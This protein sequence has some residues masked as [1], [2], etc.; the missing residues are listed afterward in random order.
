MNTK[1]FYFTGTG[2]SFI[3]AKQ[4]AERLQNCKLIPI[5]QMMKKEK[6][7]SIPEKVGFVFPLYYYGLPKIVNDFI[8]KIDLSNS[9]Y[10]FAIITRAGEEDGASFYQLKELFNTKS[11]TLDAEF[12]VEMPNNFIIEYPA[13][14]KEQQED[15]FIKAIEEIEQ[16]SN[17]INNNE[18]RLREQQK[19]R[20]YT[21]FKRINEEFQLKV[22]FSDDKFYFDEN[23]TSC[24]ICQKICPVDNILLIDGKPHWQHQCQQ[25]LACI[26]YCP[27]KSI[28]YDG[29][30][31]SNDRY[32]HP[33]V[34]IK[35]LVAQK[36]PH[37]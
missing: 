12:A 30:R 34:R 24:G 10:H 19:T 37:S 7:S 28:K 11:K 21:R 17:F 26:N 5:V 1:L 13:E 22:N 14:T 31:S 4:L 8:Q 6:V 35:D 29:Q 2:N 20:Y 9:E 32:H 33:N 27:E 15:K 23:C 3:V 18:S 25:C 16:I 36:N